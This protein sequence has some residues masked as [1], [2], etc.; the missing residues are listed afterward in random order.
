MELVLLAARLLLSGVFLVAGVAK[1]ADRRGSVQAMRDF[2]VPASYAP[3]FGTMLPIGEIAVA[4]ALIPTATARLGALGA[5]A[6]L[7]AFVAGIGYNLARG[8][9]PDCHCFGQIHSEPAGW[10][11][12]IRNGVLSLIA[13]FILVQGWDDSGASAH[14]W[15][16]DLSALQGVLLIGA[17]VSITLLAIEGW[18]LVQLLQQ[19]GRMLIRLEAL[20]SAIET[21]HPLAPAP[22]ASTRPAAGLPLG[23]KAPSFDLPDVQGERVALET[24]T[25][26]GK[27][28]LLIFS[29]PGCGPCNALLPEIGRWQ[30][31]HE[32]AMTIALVTRGEA[33]ANR[34]KGDE[35]GISR[36]L[37]QDNRE[38]AQA[39]Q[40][41]GTPAA[42]QIW[43]SGTIG[44]PLAL[45][46]DAI[47]NLVTGMAQSPGR[48]LALPNGQKNEV[49]GASAHAKSLFDA[50]VPDLKVTT[51]EGE[52][53]SLTSLAGEPTVL[54]FWNPGCGY[55]ARMLDDL[56]AAE[57]N[58]ATGSPRIVLVS[59]G[60]PD[61]NRA[62]GVRS[63][64]LLDQGF[65]VARTFGA[66][67]TPSAVLIDAQG[68]VTS[69]VA[70]GAP[71][72]LAMVA[73]PVAAGV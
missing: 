8:N 72:V 36:V 43:P 47:R 12:L 7:L 28:V 56:K 42:V 6:L 39:Y 26:S 17:F 21:G 38:V 60:D 22:A 16:G 40:V 50:P 9:R 63:T 24:L 10:S 55:C 54:L 31:Q 34:A 13:S 69:S 33:E 37:I 23:A 29:D 51:L 70:V 65:S 53:M 2:G 19:N 20:E 3:V 49:A 15:I 27:P 32:K 67:G 68:R 30:S 44:S 18:A 41:S 46:A 35:H 25:S 4:I 5:L 64:I 57:T 58:P 61:R 1:L 71:A 14:S 11:T 73:G 48:T 45:G 66:T 59:T 62:M 52:D